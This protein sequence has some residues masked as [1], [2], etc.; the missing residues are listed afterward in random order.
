MVAGGDGGFQQCFG[1]EN[2]ANFH[3]ASRGQ[4]FEAHALFLEN[5]RQAFPVNNPQEGVLRSHEHL[6]HQRLH[7]DLEVE[8]TRSIFEFHHGHREPAVF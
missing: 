6:L 7:L 3:V 5:E 4:S 2:V 8:A 1:A